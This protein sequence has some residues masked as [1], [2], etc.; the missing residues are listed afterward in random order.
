MR[1]L[2]YVVQRC[3][4]A[5]Q[6]NKNVND[7]LELWTKLFEQIRKINSEPNLM[8]Y[9]ILPYHD[10]VQYLSAVIEHVEPLK[11]YCQQDGHRMSEE[12]TFF[13]EKIK[14]ASNPRVQN[15]DSQNDKLLTILIS[16]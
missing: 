10:R 13:L 4:D 2:K 6:S 1:F 16:K 7:K 15:L 8:I 14:G 12:E 11:K 5:H 3:C 9:N